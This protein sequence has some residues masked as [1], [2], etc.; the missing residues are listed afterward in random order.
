MIRW[1][2]NAKKWKPTKDEWI[3]A[4]ACV[5]PE[6]RAR[7]GR[8]MFACDG[9]LSMAGRLLIRKAICQL[10]GIRYNE[11]Q[12]KRTKAQKPILDTDQVTID[13]SQFGF[14]VSHSGDYVVIAASRYHHKIGVDIADIRRPLSESTQDFFRLMKQQFTPEEWKRITQHPD[15]DQQLHKFYRNWA[16]KES[17]VK[18]VG[19]GL[20]LDLQRLSFHSD[21]TLTLQTRTP[22]TQAT[23]KL[24]GVLENAW[25]FEE[26]YLDEEHCVAVAYEQDDNMQ[27]DL[28]EFRVLTFEELI[29]S[30]E[31]CE[32]PGQIPQEYW[33]KFSGKSDK[34]SRR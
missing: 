3:L 13:T 12:L 32:D 10:L 25:C 2:F 17:Y 34:K 29:E 31:P 33:T 5:Q 16:L 4:A 27:K 18:A 1:A 19:I 11:I 15:E 8:F 14:N 23:F 7:I 28:S 21:E 20:G 22:V 24:D 30:A 26:C 9:R 6:E